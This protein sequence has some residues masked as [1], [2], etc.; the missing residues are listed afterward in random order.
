LRPVYF[1]NFWGCGRN[2]KLFPIKLDTCPFH[3]KTF[4]GDQK[5]NFPEAKEYALSTFKSQE[6]FLKTKTWE[7]RI[8]CGKRLNHQR[9]K[10]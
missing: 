6:T 1:F 9:K 5:I 4:K 3:D 7:V 10:A 8:L 2:A